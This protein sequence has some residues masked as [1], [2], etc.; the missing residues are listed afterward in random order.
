MV[1]NASPLI[2]LTGLDIRILF[3][4]LAEQGGAP[5]TRAQHD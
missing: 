1:L 3:F 4:S 2:A 5:H